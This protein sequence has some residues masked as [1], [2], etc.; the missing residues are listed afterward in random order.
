MA[1]AGCGRTVHE[2][3]LVDCARQVIRARREV[4]KHIPPGL[5]KDS[6]WDILLELFINGEEGGI[7]YVKQLML[8]CGTTATSAMRLIDRLETAELIAREPDPLDHRRVIV[9]LSERG[10][11]AMIAILRKATGRPDRSE[12]PNPPTSFKPRR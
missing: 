3:K 2:R 8:A 11:K 1:R 5:M 6:A 7:V 12:T 10:R 9:S 4:D